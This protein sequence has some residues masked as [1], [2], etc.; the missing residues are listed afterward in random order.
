MNRNAA[1][2]IN[3][4]RANPPKHYPGIII[5][6]HDTP[7]EPG[8][9]NVRADHEC[10]AL[11][12]TSPEGNSNKVALSLNP[13]QTPGVRDN[14]AYHLQMSLRGLSQLATEELAA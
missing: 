2:R 8:L 6:A 13:L 1:A 9:W 11:L 4:Y 3:G 12:L 5:P 7:V 10:D 14:L